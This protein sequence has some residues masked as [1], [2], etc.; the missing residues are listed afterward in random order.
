[1]TPPAES[2]HDTALSRCAREPIHTPGAIQPY[3]VLLVVEPQSLQVRERAISHPGLLKQFGEPLMQH[4]S[5]VLGGVLAPFQGVLQQA[6]V[7]SSAHVGAVHLDGHGA[8]SCWCTA[9]PR[10]FWSSWRRRFPA[11]PARWKNCIQP[12]AS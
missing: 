5:E 4:V 2:A 9:P 6:T 12:S 10:I 7:G 3:G 8:I 11:S 1:M